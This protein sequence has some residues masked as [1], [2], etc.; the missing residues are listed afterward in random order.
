MSIINWLKRMF[1]RDREES[2]PNDT[3]R[4]ES[5][6]SDTNRYESIHNDTNRYESVD[7]TIRIGESVVKTSDNRFISKEEPKIDV[8]KRQITLEKE[9]LQ[10]GV[11]AGYISRALI[12]IENSIKRIEELIATKDWISL[13]LL[14]KI[15]EITTTTHQLKELISKHETNEERRFEVILNAINT[16]KNLELS[17]PEESRPKIL[18][19]IEDLKK[20]ALS[21]K[22]E[23]ILQILREEKEISYA[24]L[25]QKLQISVDSLRGLLSKLSKINDEIERFERDGKGWV[26]LKTIRIDTYRSESYDSKSSIDNSNV[27]ENRKFHEW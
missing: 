27:E 20:A 26:R 7:T 11:A 16:L 13:T 2:I 22:M 1:V 17:L 5:I 12:D 21:P 10:L 4:Y 8:E 14:P 19:T 23:K 9:S 15:E 25:S 3:Q 6:R 18:S 24:D